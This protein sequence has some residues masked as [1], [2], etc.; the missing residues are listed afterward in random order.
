M[1]I[2]Y[3]YLVTAILAA[4]YHKHMTKKFTRLTRD[5]IRLRL[6]VKSLEGIC[7]DLE[8]LKSQQAEMNSKIS[9]LSIRLR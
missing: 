4:L 3:S 5:V 2:V 7:Q 9:A 1:L 8:S 6:T